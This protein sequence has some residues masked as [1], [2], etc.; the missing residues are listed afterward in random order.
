MFRVLCGISKRFRV[1]GGKGHDSRL[2]RACSRIP[3]QHKFFRSLVQQAFTPKA[4]E[5]LGTRIEGLA[6]DLLNDVR[7]EWDLHDDYAFPLPV[8]V[9]S[10]MLG[11]PDG[12]I[13]LFKRWSD[14]S[15][16]AMGAEDPTPFMQEMM[17]M[18]EYPQAKMH[19]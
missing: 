17:M 7:G 16:A 11:I 3:S 5:K 18:A 1:N 6:D 9:I 14:A 12:D 2:P 15:V 13:H 8:I 4:I 19:S 10:E